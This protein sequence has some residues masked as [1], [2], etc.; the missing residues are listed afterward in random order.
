MKS[1]RLITAIALFTA[2][3]SMAEPIP[4]SDRLFLEHVTRMCQWAKQHAPSGNPVVINACEPGAAPDAKGAEADLAAW[5]SYWKETDVALAD[6]LGNEWDAELNAQAAKAKAAEKAAARKRFLQS[7]P[8]MSLSDLCGLVRRG[9]APEA[10]AELEK[11]KTFSPAELA[12]VAGMKIGLGMSEDAM[13]CAWGPP[14]RANRSVGS[15]GVH[16]QY[17]YES[18][19]V[20]VE[21]GKVTSWQDQSY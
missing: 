7:I 6:K 14:G 21:N 9:K 13:L 12:Q 8:S 17:V 16:I 15:W 3:A 4:E 19:N 11:R 1:I 5:W 20:Y 2:A 18:A 10:L